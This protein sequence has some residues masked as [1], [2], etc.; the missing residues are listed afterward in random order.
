[1]TQTHF[2]YI[3]PLESA[4]HPALRL[5]ADVF[6]EKFVDP[7][8]ESPLITTI[9]PTY[10][11]P[12]LLPRAMAS[13]LQQ[14]FA[15]VRVSV[16][17]N[18]SGDET[19][20]VVAGI[21]KNDKR[22]EYHCHAT[23]IGSYNNFNFGIRAVRTPFFSLLSDDDMLAPMFYERAMAAFSQYPDAMFVSMATM[24][25]DECGQVISPPLE[26]AAPRYF[27][28]GEGFAAAAM[29]EVPNTWTGIV[30][31]TE[32]RERMGVIDI[33][34]GPF[35]D[36]GFV[37]HAAA[38]FPF[39]T[40]PGVSAVL[41]AHAVSTSGTVGPLDH[42]WMGWEERMIAAIEN[43]TEVGADVRAGARGLMKRNYR[44]IAVMHVGRALSD[45][46]VDSARQ[47]AV[48]LSYCGHPVTSFMLR[49]LIWLYRWVPP[50][51]AALRRM[52]VRRTRKVEQSR[53]A[54]HKKHGDETQFIARLAQPAEDATGGSNHSSRGRRLG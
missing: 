4:P 18:A 43:D 26:V 33:E 9:I 48:G 23:N 15:P 37:C 22:V 31:R 20:S 34:A 50:L 36:G 42:R 30:F 14:T 44:Q 6:R 29:L 25:I 38:R 8:S 12:R 53:E 24:V 13:V 17:D 27:R 5:P 54:M 16:C 21:A 40:V 7:H 11:R 1:M 19:A 45:G 10:R 3:A 52:R 47:A 28:A 2:K 35:A 46:E 49:G 41:V 39:V 32:I 51:R